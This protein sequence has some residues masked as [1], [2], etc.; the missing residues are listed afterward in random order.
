M[1]VILNLQFALILNFKINYSSRAYLSVPKPT[2]TALGR[3]PR[4]APLAM[5]PITKW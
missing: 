1:V 4:P 2:F 5:E 3:S